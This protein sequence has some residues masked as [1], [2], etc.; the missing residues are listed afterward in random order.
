MAS[1]PNLYAALAGAR[2]THFNQLLD[3]KSGLAADPLL[4]NAVPPLELRRLERD[5]LRNKAAVI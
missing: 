3:R 4:W 5:E 2:F 1:E